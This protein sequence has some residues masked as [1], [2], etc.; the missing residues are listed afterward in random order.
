MRRLPTLWLVGAAVLAPCLVSADAAA[1]DPEA[2][3]LI[4]RGLDLRQAQKDPEALVLFEQAQ[5]IAP[6]PRGQAQVALVQQAL[7]R[8]ANAERNLRAA[9]AEKDD[10]WISSRRPILEKAMTIIQA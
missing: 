9:L 10:A 7:G 3:A 5:R 8:W 1:D 4:E 6:S 2:T